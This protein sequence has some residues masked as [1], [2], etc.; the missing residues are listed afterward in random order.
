MPKKQNQ[1]ESKNDDVKTEDINE[2]EEEEEETDL[3]ECKFDFEVLK[4]KSQILI[5]ML[6]DHWDKKSRE[7]LHKQLLNLIT[8]VKI[9]L[10][11]LQVNYP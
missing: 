8:P 2:E 7:Q 10:N 9:H 5:K 6:E 11:L 1:E 4:W 3:E